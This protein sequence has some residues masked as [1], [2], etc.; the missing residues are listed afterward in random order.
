MYARV[1]KPT[2]RYLTEVSRE[3]FTLMDLRNRLKLPGT[4][5]V[6]NHSYSAFVVRGVTWSQRH[7]PTRITI[8]RAQKT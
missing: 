8:N 3:R 5:A 6:L 1:V 7:T 4:A 2:I